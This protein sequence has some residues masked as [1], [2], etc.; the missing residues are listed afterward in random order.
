MNGDG[1]IELWSIHAML[2]E[3]QPERELFV[4]FSN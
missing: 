1:E 3:S 2:H 4:L